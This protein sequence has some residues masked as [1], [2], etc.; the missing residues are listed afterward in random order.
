MLIF[1]LLESFTGYKLNDT[2]SLNSNKYGTI[3]KNYPH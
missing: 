3:G 2:Q 1:R